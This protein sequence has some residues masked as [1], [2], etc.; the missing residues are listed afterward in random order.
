MEKNQEKT[1]DRR[2]FLKKSSLLGFSAV[3]ASSILAP[4][5]LTDASTE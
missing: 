1:L 4:S 5:T 3:A 2:E